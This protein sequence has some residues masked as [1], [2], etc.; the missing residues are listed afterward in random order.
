MFLSKLGYSNWSRGY[1]KIDIF[2]C[3]PPTTVCETENAKN[4][5]DFIGD[6]ENSTM[7]ITGLSIIQQNTIKTSETNSLHHK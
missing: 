1:L 2:S 7:E 5:F 6:Q 4:N 3:G